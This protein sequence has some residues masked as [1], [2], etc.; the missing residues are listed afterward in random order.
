M[1]MMFHGQTWFIGTK[2]NS[3]GQQFLVTPRIFIFSQNQ[4]GIM[5]LPSNPERIIIPEGA[6]VYDLTDESIK[7][8]YL[9]QS[10]QSVIIKAPAGLVT[11]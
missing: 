6:I 4:H 8:L 11:Q 3:H 5:S 1:I 9:K 2:E 10:G 7:E